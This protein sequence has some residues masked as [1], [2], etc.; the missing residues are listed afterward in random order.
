MSRI[1]RLAVPIPS[2]VEVKQE[3][4]AMKV[5]GPKGSLEASLPTGISLEI[6][7][8]DRQLQAGRRPQAH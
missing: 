6:V 4:G 5:K 1:G 7:E 8:R 3:S 2:G